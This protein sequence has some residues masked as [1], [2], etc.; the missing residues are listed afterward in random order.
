MNRTAPVQDGNHNQS[1]ERK[2]IIFPNTDKGIFSP[3]FC[4][5][6]NCNPVKLYHGFTLI[7]NVSF[8]ES[9]PY[10]SPSPRIAAAMIPRASA[11]NSSSVSL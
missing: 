7:T 2:T 9:A 5:N 3:A 11:T 1:N 4:G 8:S 10:A 6:W